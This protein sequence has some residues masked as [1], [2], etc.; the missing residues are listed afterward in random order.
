[1]LNNTNYSV[2]FSSVLSVSN[3]LRPHESSMPG[4]P[5]VIVREMQIKITMRYQ[6]LPVRMAIMKKIYKQ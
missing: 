1:M 6:L 2:Q 5:V 3:S 4:L